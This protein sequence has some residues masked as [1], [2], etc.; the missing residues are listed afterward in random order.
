MTRVQAR[1]ELTKPIDDSMMEMI[2]RAHG[3]YGIE[4]VKLDPNQTSL[5][6]EYDA[7][8]L[9]RNDVDHAL[10]ASGLPTKR[11]V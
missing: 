11:R 3:I 9:T 2:D 5:T 7:S 8:R 6:V 4:M 10:S 1:Y